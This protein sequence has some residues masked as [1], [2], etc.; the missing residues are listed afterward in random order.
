MGKTQRKYSYWLSNCALKKR[1]CSD[2]KF[3]D[4]SLWWLS[5]LVN[6]DNVNNQGWYEDLNKIF[7]NKKIKYNYNFLYARFLIKFIK[8][9]V[10]KFIFTL[11]I[12]IFFKNKKKN[13]F[14]I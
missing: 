9:L 1:V 13:H 12:K 10:L 5:N 8:N 4:L 3:N 6:R 11:F 14:I 2:I 7:N